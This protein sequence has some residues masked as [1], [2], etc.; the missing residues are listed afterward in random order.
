MDEEK[1]LYFSI[2]IMALKKKLET[3]PENFEGLNNVFRT[4]ARDLSRY[5]CGKYKTLKDAE[6]QLDAVKKKYNS[7][8]VV[9]FL[10]DELISVKKALGE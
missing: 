5:F 9:A 8:F 7:A 3:T 2:Q 10:N 1:N 4:D 6:L